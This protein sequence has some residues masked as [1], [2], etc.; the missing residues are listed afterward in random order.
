MQ[1]IQMLHGT[2]EV[3]V[4]PLTNGTR[5]SKERERERERKKE[6]RVEYGGVTVKG[7]GRKRRRG[8]R[9]GRKSRARAF[10]ISHGEMEARTL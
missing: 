6:S 7:G 5:A 1:Y 3:I 9:R 8:H 4:M 2:I 10:T